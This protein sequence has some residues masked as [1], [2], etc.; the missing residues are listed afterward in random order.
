MYTD[1]NSFE[2]KNCLSFYLINDL[3]NLL[4][5]YFSFVKVLKNKDQIL[6]Q[7]NQLPFKF[8][9][10]DYYTNL[11]DLYISEQG[12]IEIVQPDF[13]LKNLSISEDGKI[14]GPIENFKTIDLNIKNQNSY[15]DLEFVKYIQYYYENIDIFCTKYDFII[16]DPNIGKYIYQFYSNITKIH[17]FYKFKDVFDDSEHYIMIAKLKN[18]LYICYEF[19]IDFDYQQMRSTNHNFYISYQLDKLIYDLVE[20]HIREKFYSH[21]KF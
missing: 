17:Y 2:I 18:N 3:I 16:P 12:D 4:L 8:F 9:K 5:K 11:I 19:F 20:D 7:F 13:K 10:K 1:F 14:V 21:Q 15:T 6:S